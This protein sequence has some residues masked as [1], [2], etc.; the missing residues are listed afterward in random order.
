MSTKSRFE[1]GAKGNSEMAYSVYLS[2]IHVNVFWSMSFDE[3]AASSY[4]KKKKGALGR[5]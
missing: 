2:V 4:K 5:Q 3:V 1:K